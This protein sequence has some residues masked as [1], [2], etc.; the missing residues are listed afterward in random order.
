M[1]R[2][3]ALTAGVT[4]LFSTGCKTDGEW[5]VRKALG[6]DEPSS[7]R[8]V[9]PTA[10]EVAKIPSAPPDLMARV[11]NLGRKIIAQNT[12]TGIDP[13]F[14]TAGVKEN[15]LFHV[16]TEQLVISQGLVEMCQSDAELAAVLCSELGQMV[17]EKRTAK[18]LGR[19]AG[20]I[21]DATAGG[22][23]IFPGGT[24]FDAGRQVE[25][26]R[27]E[28]QFPKDGSRAAA[29]DA[30]STARELLDHAG[31]SPLELDRVTWLLKQSDRG[32]KIR[33]QF[34]GTAP[35]PEWKK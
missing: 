25:L 20:P 15:V 22:G 16:G 32:E 1:N 17:I 19:D 35:A 33:K 18:A 31:Y 24:A 27:H 13:V 7:P 6:L 26:A 14:F 12:F 11:E 30:V 8:V 5:S 10:K 21:P 3:A 34:G 4:L 29:V 2:L 23:P 28:Q 9:K